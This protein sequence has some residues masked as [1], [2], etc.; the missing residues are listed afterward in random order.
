[1]QSFTTLKVLR[2]SASILIRPIFSAS[3]ISIPTTGMRS[4]DPG[5]ER[6]SK[7]AYLNI[8]FLL[9]TTPAA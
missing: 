5:E 2:P 1:M 9:V 8:G 3:S 4:S 6:V 7:G